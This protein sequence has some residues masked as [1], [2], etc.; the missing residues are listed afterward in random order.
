M[1]KVPEIAYR[2]E[3]G[4]LFSLFFR[5]TMSNLIVEVCWNTK[6]ATAQV[7]WDPITWSVDIRSDLEDWGAWF[8]QHGVKHSRVFM[9]VENWFMMAEDPDGKFIRLNTEEEHEWTKYPDEGLHLPY[10]RFA[11]YAERRYF[12]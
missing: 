1:A 6:Q 7:G 2:N 12:R 3:R 8:D 5:H 4:E 10:M 11:F 9:G